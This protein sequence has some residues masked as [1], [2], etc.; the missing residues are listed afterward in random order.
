MS[1]LKFSSRPHMF[2]L[3]TILLVMHMSNFIT[4][5][6]HWLCYSTCPTNALLLLIRTH[7]H[8]PYDFGYYLII[9]FLFDPVIAT[10]ILP[11]DLVKLME[12]MQLDKTNKSLVGMRLGTL[13]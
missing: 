4:L 8:L 5:L 13:T 9:Y 6:R 1:S 12:N 7:N 11:S 2:F 3:I 10:T